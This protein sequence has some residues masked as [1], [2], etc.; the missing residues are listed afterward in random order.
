MKQTK[1]TADVEG[2]YWLTLF[3]VAFGIQLCYIALILV[4]EEFFGA[5]LAFLPLVLMPLFECVLGGIYGFLVYRRAQRRARAVGIALGALAAAGLL[6]E[7]ACIALEG[8][9]G[10]WSVLLYDLLIVLS[11]LL[12]LVFGFRVEGL[13]RIIHQRRTKFDD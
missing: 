9:R 10:E 3:F 13:R 2:T 4:T 5:M 11:L 8:W 1:R 12:G 6:Y 7:L